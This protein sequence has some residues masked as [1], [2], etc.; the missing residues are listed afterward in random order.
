MT[1]PKVRDAEGLLKTISYCV[2]AK[3]I[4]DIISDALRR[5]ARSNL[6]EF[7]REEDGIEQSLDLK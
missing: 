7:G 6:E 3:I 5:I 4:A 2:E 1:G